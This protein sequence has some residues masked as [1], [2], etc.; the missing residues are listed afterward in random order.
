MANGF[1]ADFGQHTA[2]VYGEQSWTDYFGMD[3]KYESLFP[4]IRQSLLNQL[5]PNYYRDTITGITSQY[6]GQIGEQMSALGSGLMGGIGR[7][8]SYVEGKQQQA[9]SPLL[10]QLT[11]GYETIQRNI[12]DAETQVDRGI[13]DAISTFIDLDF[14]EGEDWFNS[15]DYVDGIYFCEDGSSTTNPDECADESGCL[16]SYNLLGQ[17]VSCCG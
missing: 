11:G 15:G 5:D 7:S 17:C 16:P 9:M 12:G 13:A 8:K 4:N 10:S 6:E 1:Q 2:P 14:D 3:S